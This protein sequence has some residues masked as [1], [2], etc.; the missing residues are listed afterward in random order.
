L[1]SALVLF[2]FTMGLVGDAT[3]AGSSVSLVLLVSGVMA[4]VILS[5]LLRFG[6]L[7]A[8]VMGTVFGWLTAAPLTLDASSWYAGRSFL[9]LG[10]CAAVA[11]YGFIVSLG[12]QPVFGTP[13]F[14]E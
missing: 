2:I 3:L 11:I 4:A 12:R 13:L 5:V 8:I 10:A 7:A 6:L 14:D 9:V 1:A